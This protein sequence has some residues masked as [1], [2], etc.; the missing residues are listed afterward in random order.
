LI[1]MPT[2]ILITRD[3]KIAKKYIGILSADQVVK[4]VEAQL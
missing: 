4:D 2:S 1:G 3:G